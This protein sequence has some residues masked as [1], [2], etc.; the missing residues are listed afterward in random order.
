MSNKIDRWDF[1]VLVSLQNMQD[2]ITRQEELEKINTELNK[3]VEE[4]ET[5]QNNQTDELNEMLKKIQSTEITMEDCR[6][7]N[8]KLK[9]KIDELSNECRNLDIQ[10]TVMKSLQLYCLLLLLFEL[11]KKINFMLSIFR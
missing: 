10:Q 1:F 6:K 11:K 9:S 4:F 8:V 2:Y 3:K 7:E 5:L